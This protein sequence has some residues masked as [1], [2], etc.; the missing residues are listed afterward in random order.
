MFGNIVKEPILND[1]FE[2]NYIGNIVKE[3]TLYNQ[4]QR[5]NTEKACGGAKFNQQFLKL[6]SQIQ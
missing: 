1:L 3:P 2:R 6:G 4:N 5:N